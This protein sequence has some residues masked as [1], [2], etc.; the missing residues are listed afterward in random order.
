[1]LPRDS[2]QTKSQRMELLAQH[3]QNKKEFKDFIHTYKLNGWKMNKSK[4]TRKL[5]SR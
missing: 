2:Q 4:K 1:M 3:K 5:Y